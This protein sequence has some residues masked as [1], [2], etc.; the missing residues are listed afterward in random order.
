MPSL[1][2]LHRVQVPG[3]LTFLLPELRKKLCIGGVTVG[4]LPTSAHD[5]PT[6]TIT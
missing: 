2:S 1:C 4:T 3:I 5:E 6:L